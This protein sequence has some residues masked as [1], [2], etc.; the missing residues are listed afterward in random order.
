MNA[1]YCIVFLFFFAVLFMTM[2]TKAG[3]FVV[4]T[5]NRCLA[6]IVFITVMNQ[7][8]IFS[9]QNL[10]VR[11]NEISVCIS[12]VFGIIGLIFLYAF[13]WLLTI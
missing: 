9:G 6:G 5:V 12:G 8:I 11:I 13:Q 1:T 4:K 10:Q 2:G 7:L 3:I